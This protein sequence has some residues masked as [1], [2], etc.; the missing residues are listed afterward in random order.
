MLSFEVNIRICQPENR[1]VHPDEHQVRG[2][3][4]PDVNQEEFTNCFLYDTVSLFLCLFKVVS[5]YSR[6]MF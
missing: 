1:D 4:N 2:L 5:Y 3:T 6:E